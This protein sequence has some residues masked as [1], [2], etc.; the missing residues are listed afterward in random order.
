[1]TV[2]ILFMLQITPFHDHFFPQPEAEEYK[3]KAA[4]IYNFTYFVEWSDTNKSP[5]FIIGIVGKSEIIE[6]FQEISK[7]KKVKGKKIVVKVFNEN[8]DITPCDVL[9]IPKSKE[10][11]THEVL[12]KSPKKNTLII[13]ETNGWR[14]DE[15]DINFVIIDD[16]VKFEV[17]KKTL[18]KKNLK[19][20]S[21]LL[22]LAIM[23]E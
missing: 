19:F 8:E 20:S 23:V 4:F 21:Q 17:S 9:F 5:E 15:A 13:T 2:F 6:P 12:N 18:E 1:M 14:M 10:S 11:K 7:K 3:I 22:K 16:Q